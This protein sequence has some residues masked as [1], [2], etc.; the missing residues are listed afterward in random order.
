VGS[1]NFVNEEAV[2][3][4]RLLRQKKKERKKKENWLFATDIIIVTY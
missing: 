4:G 2:A 3:H 1:R